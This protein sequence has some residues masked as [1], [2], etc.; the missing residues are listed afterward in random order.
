MWY[1]QLNKWPYCNA[2]RSMANL[3]IVSFT[4]SQINHRISQSGSIHQSIS[5]APC[6][7]GILHLG[8]FYFVWGAWGG[9]RGHSKMMP[10]VHNLPLSGE[11][12]EDTRA[13]TVETDNNN[14]IQKSSGKSRK[15][16]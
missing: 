12:R 5:Q 7:K 2:M 15:Y 10:C 11:R 8:A 13:V 6:T 4:T 3:L 16:V 14:N 1:I 9:G